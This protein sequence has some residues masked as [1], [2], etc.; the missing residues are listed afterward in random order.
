MSLQINEEMLSDLVRQFEIGTLT[1]F[2]R[3]GEQSG[4]SKLITATKS[5][6]KTLKKVAKKRN[7]NN[8]QFKTG[9]KAKI[10][11]DN[12]SKTINK[13]TKEQKCLKLVMF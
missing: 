11:A 8:K 10:S 1:D 13:D 4:S 5:A 9:K 6:K 3:E 2:K 7:K 12:K